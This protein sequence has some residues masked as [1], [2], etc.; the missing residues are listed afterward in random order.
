MFAR[1]ETTQS[2]TATA[3]TLARLLYALRTEGDEQTDRG[4][5]RWTSNETPA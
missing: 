3:H 2:V 5:D 4:Q 1:V